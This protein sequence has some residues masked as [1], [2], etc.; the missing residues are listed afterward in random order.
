MVLVRS[1]QYVSIPL[2][3]CVRA[4]NFIRAAVLFRNSLE[5]GE[6]EPEMFH[7][8]PQK[9]DNELFRNIVRLELHNNVKLM[10]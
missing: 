6:L 9:S 5:K 1:L 2:L 4:T 3:Q 8:D 7:L 10:H